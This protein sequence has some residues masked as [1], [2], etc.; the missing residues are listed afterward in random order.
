MGKTIDGYL[1]RLALVISTSHSRFNDN[2]ANIVV[3]ILFL[4]RDSSAIMSVSEIQNGIQ[5]K[6]EIWKLYT[7]NV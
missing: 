1:F 5:N 3:Y 7:E 6:L 2:L 4:N